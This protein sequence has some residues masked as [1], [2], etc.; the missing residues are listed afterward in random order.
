MVVLV[1]INIPVHIIL[2]APSPFDVKYT[3][4][5]FPHFSQLGQHEQF[6]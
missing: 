5:F 6:Q 3:F 2:L 4:E 1:G